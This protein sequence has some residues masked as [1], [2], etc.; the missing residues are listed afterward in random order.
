MVQIAQSLNRVRG[1]KKSR[2][3]K[4]VTVSIPC[5]SGSIAQR[6]QPKVETINLDLLLS[7]DQNHTAIYEYGSRARWMPKFV[8]VFIRGRLAAV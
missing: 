1:N 7:A 4:S 6:G 3:V 8:R 5:V 2:P